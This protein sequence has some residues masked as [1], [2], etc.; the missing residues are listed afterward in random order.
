MNSPKVGWCHDSEI[1]NPKSEIR[2]KPEIRGPKSYVLPDSAGSSDFGLRISFE[3]RISN[4]GFPKRFR[5]NPDSPKTPQEE[6]EMR[7]LALLLGEL[8]EEEA[9]AWRAA[10]ATN[11]EL[12]KLH[13]RLK[14]TVN[15]VREAA[16]IPTEPK[17]AQAA[18]LQL[19]EERRK[20]LLTR[21]LIPSLKER[22][23]KPHR[24]F[25]LTLVEVLVV[26]AILG[27]LA[28]MMLPALSKAKSKAQSVAVRSNLQQLELAKRLWADDNKKSAGDAP[29]FDDLKPYLG[30]RCEL[31]SV[32]GETYV[33][34]RVVEP[35]AADLVA[36]QV[37]HLL[38]RL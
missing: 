18:P 33:A 20:K 37:G 23:R 6:M 34:A 26:V 15:L 10:I 17:S 4:F 36:Q 3:F 5:M 7:L 9:A 8:P 30:G 24:R 35:T 13:G 19:S 16:A 27:I 14:Q 25:P 29:T 28:A 32:G 1:R 38:G 31:P 21:F 11:P 12:A 2:R 22:D